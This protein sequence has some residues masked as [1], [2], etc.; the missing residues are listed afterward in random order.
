MK[1]LRGIC[2]SAQIRTE[3]RAIAVRVRGLCTPS[4]VWV[5]KGDSN[6]HPTQ[7]PTPPRSLWDKR[8]MK[9]DLN[10]D[11]CQRFSQHEQQPDDPGSP[12]SGRFWSQLRLNGGER[13]GCCWDRDR[14]LRK[15]PASPPPA[16]F[17][18]S[19]TSPV[20]CSVFLL[21]NQPSDR[22]QRGR[23]QESTRG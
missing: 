11:F 5:V 18:P 14:D 21:H 16:C 23:S 3:S 4:C 1:R 9:T 8:L 10:A 13:S 7:V 22:G 6:P 12:F 19:F 17:T 2:K 20:V 15:T